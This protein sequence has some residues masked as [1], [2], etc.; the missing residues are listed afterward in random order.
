MNASGH[1]ENL[2]IT[3]LAGPCTNTVW[4]LMP[5]HWKIGALGSSTQ[6]WFR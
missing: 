2:A 5:L 4:P 3:T 1:V 6:N